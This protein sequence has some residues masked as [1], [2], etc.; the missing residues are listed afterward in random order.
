MEELD[1]TR[2]FQED[3]PE[4]SRQRRL[5]GA[6]QREGMTEA[7]AGLEDLWRACLEG[8]RLPAFNLHPEDLVDLQLNWRSRSDAIPEKG[9]SAAEA[10]GPDR[11]QAD[12]GGSPGAD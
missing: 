6:A 2:R 3:V 7:G 8:F 4:R 10:Q 1:A 9:N 11:A 5:L 12:A